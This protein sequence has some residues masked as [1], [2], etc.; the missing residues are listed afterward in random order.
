MTDPLRAAIVAELVRQARK[1]GGWVSH[2]EY[3]PPGWEAAEDGEWRERFQYD[4]RINLDE[5]CAAIRRS[6]ATPF[7][8]RTPT[9]SETG[10][11]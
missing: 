8:A 5:L 9:T 1:R 2:E 6:L 7:E 4:G 3:P 10:K 11:A